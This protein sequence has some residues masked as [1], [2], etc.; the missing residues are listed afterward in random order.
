MKCIKCQRVANPLP[1]FSGEGSVRYWMM[2]GESHR[3]MRLGFLHAFY[4]QTLQNHDRR[5]HP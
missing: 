1:R 2:Q 3:M 4:Y 5:K